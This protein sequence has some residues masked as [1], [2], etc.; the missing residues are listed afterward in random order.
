MAFPSESLNAAFARAQLLIREWQIP[1]SD[2]L[3]TWYEKRRKDHG[4]GYGH[5]ARK[6]T[7]PVIGLEVRPDFGESD[8]W[9]VDIIIGFPKNPDMRE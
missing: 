4:D 2:K 9:Y 8:K 6:G 1:D 7:M 5:L 3:K